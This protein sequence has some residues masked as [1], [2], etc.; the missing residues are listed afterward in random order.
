MGLLSRNDNR[1]HMQF[2]EVKNASPGCFAEVNVPGQ[3]AGYSLT[4]G[5]IVPAERVGLMNER[6]ASRRYELSFPILVHATDL[7]QTSTHA[8]RTR[9][10][11]A[12]GLYFVLPVSL[13]P[14]VAIQFT[15]T[16]KLMGGHMFLRGTGNILRVTACC[17][18]GYGIASSVER[19]DISRDEEGLGSLVDWED[20]L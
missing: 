11:S 12:R 5:T 18:P 6:R 7:E 15:I 17:D 19:W 1:C 14:G 20:D 10:I 8:G 9:E 16:T 4:K 13:K 3:M 2:T